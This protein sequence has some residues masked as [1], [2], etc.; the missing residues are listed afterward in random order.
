[1]SAVLT[2]AGKEIRSAYRNR[3]ILLIT[4]LFLA[5]SVL[6]VYIG[7]STKTAEVRLY[8]ETVAML[9]AQGTTSLP[10]APEIS[11]LTMLG[12]FTEYVAIVGA[13]LAV[14]LGFD[15][16]T[17]EKESGGLKLILSRPVFR[18]TLING[19]LLGNGAIIAAI[20]T[21][22]LGFTVALLVLVGGV[23]P[24][25]SEFARLLGF[26]ALAFVYMGFFLVTA[27]VLSMHMK[28][29][30]SVFLVSLVIWIAAAFVIPQMAQTQMI[31]STV[32]SSVTGVVNQIPQDTALSR[33][34]DYLSPT[35]HLRDIGNTLLEVSPGSAA[36]PAGT[37]LADGLRAFFVL[38]AAGVAVGAAGYVG[39][40]RSEK[41]SLE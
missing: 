19:K 24:T 32:V 29:S 11:T 39:F 8:N 5:L 18:D 30:A 35:W 15:S 33:T 4:V 17:E 2:I 13:I 25:M 3:M 1:M 38:L 23:W 26:T 37:L 20:L 22:A 10:P 6:S 16:L 40:L 27:M 12:N 41:L 7:G 34:L 14:M 28:S 9:T 21:G 36:L 31:N